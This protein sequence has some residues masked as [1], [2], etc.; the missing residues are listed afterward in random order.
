MVIKAQISF[1]AVLLLQVKTSC[2]CVALVFAYKPQLGSMTSRQCLAGRCV[3]CWSFR[4]SGVN[5][6][7]FL[8]VELPAGK[9]GAKQAVVRQEDTAEEADLLEAAIEVVAEMQ[10]TAEELK[11]S[12]GTP[13]DKDAHASTA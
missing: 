7:R 9:R 3:A 6:C 1:S 11:V 12:R 5:I 4:G 2:M 10:L 13:Q 8:T